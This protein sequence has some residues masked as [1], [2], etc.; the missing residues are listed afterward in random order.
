MGGFL[1]DKLGDA[2][3]FGLKGAPG[4][5]APYLVGKGVEVT[6]G[7]DGLSGVQEDVHAGFGRGAESLVTGVTD[8]LASP[9]DSLKGL[10][11]LATTFG[12]ASH[13]RD[14]WEMLA[15]GKSFGEVQRGKADQMQQLGEDLLATYGETADENGAAGVVGHL[16]FDVLTALGTGGAGAAVKGGLTG[17]KTA[18]RGSSKLDGPRPLGEGDLP[19]N[20]GAVIDADG[21]LFDGDGRAVPDKLGRLQVRIEGFDVSG[22]YLRRADRA[23]DRLARKNLGVEDALG[24]VRERLGRKGDHSSRDEDY[25]DAAFQPR[26]GLAPLTTPLFDRYAGYAGRANPDGETRGV[27]VS[28]KVAQLDGRDIRLSA[29]IGG[30]PPTAFN[31]PLSRADR[32]AVNSHID[33]LAVRARDKRTPVGESVEAV[34]EIHWLLANSAPARRGSAAFADIYTRSLLRARGLQDPPLRPGVGADLEALVTDLGT[35]RKSYAS[36]FEAPLR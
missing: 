4:L 27:P 33:S 36:F 5:N 3:E 19:M 10:G 28:E 29:I 24:Y 14:G 22:D 6:T 1:G 21:R 30:D 8:G 23:T 16:G 34:G 12:P 31:L 25:A 15:Q 20:N 7:W 17:L 9:L 13:L 32:V 11:N 2:L 35:Y 26:E 18:L